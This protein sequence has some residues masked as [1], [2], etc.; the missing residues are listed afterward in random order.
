ML[1]P[2]INQFQRTVT[3][4]GFVCFIVTAF[5]SFALSACSNSNTSAPPATAPGAQANSPAGGAGSAPPAPEVSVI[6]VQ[7]A[8]TSI[9][10]EFSGQTIGSR[11]TEVRARV[12]GILQKRL[13]EEGSVVKAGTPLFQI[14]SASFQNQVQSTQAAVAVA[15]ARFSQAK[16]DEAR[17]A[18]LVAEKA[19]SQKEFDDARSALELAGANLRQ[20]QAQ[21]QEALL[22]LSY[23]K[24]LAP[25]G[26]VTGVAVKSEGSLLTNADSLLT[27]ITQTD[28]L[29]VNFTIPESEFLQLNKQV[30]SGQLTVPGK[31]ASNGSLGFSVKLKLADGSFSPLTGTLN[32]ASNRVNPQTGN[33]DVRAQIA[34]PDASLKPGQFVRVVLGGAIRPN[35][36]SVPQ[37]AVIDS[38]FGKIVFVV[39]PD[40]K[41]SPR[42]VELDGWSKGNWIITKG[43]QSGERVLVEGFIKANTPGMTVKPV[44][45]VAAT[46][47]S[48]GDAPATPAPA[49]KN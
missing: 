7:A 33:V 26:G 29:F 19:I 12:P 20:I 46:T 21:A 28:P 45:Y 16:R 41:L 13:F 37:R 48:G 6:T 10:L 5:F 32:F 30:N 43:L 47:T 3:N 25:I 8:Q 22:N 38:P 36:I 2:K 15:Q 44:P 40:N 49:A 18:P 1:K 42:P 17:L 31:R 11:E 14:D 4:P 9:D 34:N 35:V 39:S 23:T 27:Q 24:V